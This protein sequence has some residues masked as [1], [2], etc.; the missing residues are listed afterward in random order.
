MA[1]FRPCALLA[2]LALLVVPMQPVAAEAAAAAIPPVPAY[3]ELPLPDDAALTVAPDGELRWLGN[4]PI[5][6]PPKGLPKGCWAWEL[7]MARWHPAS[8]RTALAPLQ[9]GL[10]GFVYRQL[11]LPAGL[12]A[13]TQTGCQD[14]EA[15]WRFVLLPGHGGPAL[16]LVTGEDFDL[17]QMELL[18]LGDAAAALVTREPKTRH[19]KVYTVQ[20]TRGRLELTAMPVLPIAYR[21]DFASAVAGKDQVMVLG[22][23]DARYRGCSPCR[24]ETHLLDLKTRTWRDGP[25]ML[26]ARSELAASTLPDGSV[27]ATGGWT[28]AADWGSGG[29]RTAERW[30]PATDRFEALPPMPNG[31]ARHKH[32]WWDAPWGRELLAVQGLAGSAQALDTRTWTWRTVGEWRSGSQEGGC[33]FYPFVA[34]GNAY[35]WLVNRTEGHYSSKSCAEQKFA[36]LSLLRPPAGARP[37]AEAPPESALVS[38]RDGAAFVPAEGDAPALA[39]GGARHAGMNAFVITGAVEAIGRDGRVATLPSL[40][41][42]RQDARAFRAAGGVLV[43]GGSGPDSPYGGVR[44]P[45]PLKAEWLALPGGTPGTWQEVGGDGPPASAALAQLPDGGLLA[46]GPGGDLRQWK[47]AVRNG[48]PVFESS[49]WPALERERRHGDGEGEAMRIRALEDGRVVVAGGMERPERIAVYSLVPEEP[50]T[51]VGIG[52][53]LPWRHYDLFDPA[54]QRW[55]VSAPAQAAGGRALILGDGRVIKATPLPQTEAEAAAGPPRFVLEASD[56]AGATWAP[57]ASQGSRLRINA[58]YKLF[59]LEGELLASGEVDGLGTGG[60]PSGV[61]WRNP[62]TGAWELLWQAAPQDNWRDH[63]GRILRRTLTGA[64]G[65]P[66]TLLI[67]VEGL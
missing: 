53:F 21:G 6:P 52:D 46:L 33:G 63:Q 8:G 57:L 18:P 27:L 65:S 58:R 28:K 1:S 44:R 38:Y 39:I 3:A 10:S 36:S 47:L 12:L 29:S 43:V 61:E 13:L 5:E 14:G 34:G 56:R 55:T 20:R 35:A 24:A 31:T 51:Y 37:S 22:G 67:P 2:S 26:E 54:S 59:T 23:S 45:Q 62:A 9:P 19:I 32:L 48:A 64:G 15:Q 4:R 7:R 49:A 25:P 40:R 16:Q 30:N 17:L 42:A 41:T 11:P 60:G 66:K 50:D